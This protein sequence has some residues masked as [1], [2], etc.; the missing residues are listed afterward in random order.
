MGKKDSRWFISKCKLLSGH[1]HRWG[2]G[3]LDCKI[4]ITH[5][6]LK[7]CY[8][9]QILKNFFQER[10]FTADFKYGDAAWTSLTVAND[11]EDEYVCIF[12]FA[13]GYIAKMSRT[14]MAE[15]KSAQGTGHRNRDKA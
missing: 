7:I 5:F 14:M 13:D 6:N 2:T 3:K 9:N 4:I 12:L 15:S 1:Q 10:K 8:D 11:K